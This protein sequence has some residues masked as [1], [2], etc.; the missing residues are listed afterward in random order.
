VTASFG[1]LFNEA[2]HQ[3]AAGSGSG[4][5]TVDIRYTTID[6][7]PLA[8][9]GYVL[10]TGPD[11]QQFAVRAGPAARGAGIGL[12]Q[13]SGGGGIFGTLQA[14]ART[15]DSA[16]LDYKVAAGRLGDRSHP[17][18]GASCKP[19]KSCPVDDGDDTQATRD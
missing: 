8:R 11:G 14:Q 19:V 1:Y 4:Q 13:S 9:H 18:H 6:G 15:Y 10:V 16:L 12:P 5:T 3:L 2:A 7:V 17:S